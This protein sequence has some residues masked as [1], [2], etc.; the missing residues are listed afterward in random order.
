MGDEI[1]IFLVVILAIGGLMMMSALLAC[2]ACI[3]RDLCCRPEDRSK[4]RRAQSPH[5][6]PDDPNRPR[7][8]A[9]LLNDITQ[10]ESMPTESEKV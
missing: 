4:R 2:Y 7:L 6:E 3:F 5:H 10:G 8:E 9:M 1:S